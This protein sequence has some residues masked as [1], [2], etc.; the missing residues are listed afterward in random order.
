MKRKSILCLT[1]AMLLT[2]SACSSKPA[3]TQMAEDENVSSSETPAHDKEISSEPEVS[4]Q[5][6]AEE[7]PE[8][9]SLQTCT[10]DNITFSVDASW[11][12][13]SGMEGTFLIPDE[14]CAY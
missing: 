4:D 3:K 11:Q 13:Q 8:T 6:N 1:A 7:V 2:L 12:P 14:A 5:D 10:V 9:I